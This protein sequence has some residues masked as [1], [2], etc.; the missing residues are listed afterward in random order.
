MM[1]KRKLSRLVD[2]NYIYIF[3]CLLN[4]FFLNQAM[5]LALGKRIR[6]VDTQLVLVLPRLE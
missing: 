6:L 3:H 5:I 4:F 1:H 2:L